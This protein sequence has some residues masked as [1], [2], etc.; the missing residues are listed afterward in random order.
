M[1]D[2][3]GSNITSEDASRFDR[4]LNPGLGRLDMA[5]RLRQ[6]R[7]DVDAL[8]VGVTA[9]GI[10]AALATDAAD[11][12]VGTAAITNASSVTVSGSIGVHGATP[13]AQPGAIADPTDEPTLITAVTAVLSALE[14]YGLIAS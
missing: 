1:A 8:S 12:D 10:K 9:A 5:R 2:P 3:Y 7:I 6:M 13:P 14:A 11:L 4:T